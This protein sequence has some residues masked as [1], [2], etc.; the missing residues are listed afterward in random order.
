MVPS[1]GK[2]QNLGVMYHICIDSQDYSFM[3]KIST[4]FILISY[5]FFCYCL[6]PF[7]LDFCYLTISQVITPI[8][9]ICFLLIFLLLIS[10]FW[11]SLIHVIVACP[12]PM[13]SCLYVLFM[14][15]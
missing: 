8:S 6:L 2:G 9:L 15:F 4:Y 13:A 14:A 7:F 10:F 11:G 3:L 5:L 12:L 1:Y